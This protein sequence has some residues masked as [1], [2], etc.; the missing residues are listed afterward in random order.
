[1]GLTTAVDGLLRAGL[2]G[3]FGGA[4]PPI[5][6]AVTRVDLIVD[7]LP[8][9]TALSEPRAYDGVDTLPF[10]AA[11]PYQL[12]QPPAAGPRRVWL[13]RDTGRLTLSDAQTVWDATDPRKFTLVLDGVD[14]TGVTGVGVQ[15][16]VIAVRT[17][18]TATETVHIGLTGDPAAVEKAES[19]VLA[20]VA[21][22]RATLLTASTVNDGVY[23]STVVTDSLT[24]TGSSTI[25]G[26][27]AIALKAHLRFTGSRALRADE[28]VAIK[29]IGIP[30]SVGRPVDIAIDV[31]A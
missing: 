18:L 11:G 9:A 27:R 10:A 23:G 14:V 5:A 26:G 2:P 22:D 28:G 25:D 12:S 20:A 19:L 15:Y 4:S 16:M 8:Q 6:L 1:M 29:H 7:P 3:L 24:V 21:L 31:D 30:G 17:D 13:A